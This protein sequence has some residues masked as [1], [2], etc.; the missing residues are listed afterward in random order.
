VKKAKKRLKA[1][2]NELGMDEDQ[3]PPR[4][5]LPK[6]MDSSGWRE[7]KSEKKKNP[8]KEGEAPINHYKG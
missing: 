3:P 6:G 8:E 5:S 7:L 2:R 4:K 1:R